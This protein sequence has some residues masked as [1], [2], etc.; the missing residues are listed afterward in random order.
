MI[1]EMHHS[2]TEDEVCLKMHHSYPISSFYGAVIFMLMWTLEVISRLQAGVCTWL[3]PH[4][5]RNKYLGL[6]M[7]T[8]KVGWHRRGGGFD[9]AVQ[10]SHQSSPL[11]MASTWI[12]LILVGTKQE[13]LLLYLCPTG[14]S[15]FEGPLTCSIGFLKELH[16]FPKARNLSN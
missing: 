8:S 16:L 1:T 14:K 6:E 7:T 12:H 9:L 10:I 3:K 4:K 15:Q 13:S 11:A 2:F 5:K